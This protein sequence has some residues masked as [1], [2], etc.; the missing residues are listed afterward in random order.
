MTL[1][2]CGITFPQVIRSFGNRALNRYFEADDLSGLCVPNVAW[3]GRML[4]VV[5]WL[6][7]E[8]VVEID[9]IPTLRVA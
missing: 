1:A 4:R 7:G 5:E 8:K 3:V 9:A 6:Y 2:S